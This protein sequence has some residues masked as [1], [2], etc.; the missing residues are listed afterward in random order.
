[1]ATDHIR[2][3]VLA[4][5]ASSRGEG[6]DVDAIPFQAPAVLGMRRAGRPLA[7]GEVG[8]D[9]ERAATRT[10]PGYVDTPLTAP[11]PVIMTL[12]GLTSR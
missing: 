11:V 10:A 12:A 5:D 6:E 4:R 8:A 1:M 7:D 9:A 2:Y 3:D